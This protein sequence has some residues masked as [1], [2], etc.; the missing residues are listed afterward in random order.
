MPRLPD[1]Y[2]A[3]RIALGAAFAVVL[4]TAPVWGWLLR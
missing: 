4:V 1:R 3:Y 2:R